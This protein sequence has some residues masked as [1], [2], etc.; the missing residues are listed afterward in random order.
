MSD[1][2]IINYYINELA[3]VKHQYFVEKAE[4]EEKSAKIS[5]LTSA[6]AALES[7]K[8]TLQSELSDVQTKYNAIKEQVGSGPS[9]GNPSAPATPEVP[10]G[11]HF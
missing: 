4:N 8:A 1:Q 10:S 6:N 7:D 11:G 9:T 5:D 3:S 2:T